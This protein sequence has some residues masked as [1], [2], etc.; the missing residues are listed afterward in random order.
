[1]TTTPEL[2]DRSP[3]RNTE[4]IGNLQVGHGSIKV[5][6]IA[7]RTVGRVV[8]VALPS[9]NARRRVLGRLGARC[10]SDGATV[11]LRNDAGQYFTLFDKAEPEWEYKEGPLT[12]APGVELPDVTK[13]KGL[14]VECRSESQFA[15]LVKEIADGSESEVWVE[16]GDGVIWRASDVDP[17]RVRL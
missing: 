5:P 9:E 11:Q 16:D 1:M 4:T 3:S 15:S 8:K 17:D 14:A 12:A 13:M 2:L 7:V 10:S 6:K